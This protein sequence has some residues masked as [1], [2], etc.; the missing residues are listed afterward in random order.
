M[1]CALVVQKCCS[2]LVVVR[3]AYFDYYAKNEA[4]TGIPT[5]HFLFLFSSRHDLA[6]RAS[7]F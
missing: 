1:I 6:L 5:F 2:V 7:N 4:N 3:D